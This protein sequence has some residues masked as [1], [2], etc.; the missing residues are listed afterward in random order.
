VQVTTLKGLT[1][2]PEGSEV[3]GR[4]GAFNMPDGI[5]TDSSGNLYVA[6]TVNMSHPEGQPPAGVV[7]TLA[8]LAGS[9]GSTTGPAVR[10]DSIFQKAFAVDSRAMSM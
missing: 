8:G 5:A 9:R 6:D 7:T 4:P 3:S 2:T 1:W 10:R